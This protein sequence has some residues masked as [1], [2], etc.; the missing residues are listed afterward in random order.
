MLPAGFRLTRLASS[1]VFLGIVVGALFA[2]EASRPPDGEPT[3]MD[4]VVRVHVLTID[5]DVDEHDDHPDAGAAYRLNPNLWGA[6]DM[7]V[8]IHYNPAG[9]PAGIPVESLIVSAAAQWT[10]VPSSFFAFDYRGT[11]GAE[12]GACASPARQLDGRNT[13]T[14]T[15]SLASGTLGITCSVWS[16][17][18]SGRL[19]EFDIMLNASISWGRS[20][21]LAA[22]QF[23]LASTI[24]HELGHGAGIGHPCTGGGGCSADEREAVMYPSLRR[25]EQR[26]V[27]RADDIAAL[28]AAYPAAEAPPGLFNPVGRLVVPGVGRD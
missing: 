6:S 18:P 8:P 23:D 3:Q 21:T 16:G 9:A 17:G 7:P 10:N 4:L 25:G 14:F 22:N 28:S 26:N 12:A 27:L 24:L 15:T 11:T 19:V 13:I 5:G 1:A 20:E 2:A